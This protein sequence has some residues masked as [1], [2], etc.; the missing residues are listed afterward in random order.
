LRRLLD[1]DLFLSF[2]LQRKTCHNL[3]GKN[4]QLHFTASGK[5]FP[6]FKRNAS[7]YAQ[8]ALSLDGGVGSPRP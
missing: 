4:W 8:N 3:P 6:L 2:F 1:Q 5:I 7:K